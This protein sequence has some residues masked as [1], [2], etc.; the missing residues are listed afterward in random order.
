MTPL[1]TSEDNFGKCWLVLAVWEVQVRVGGSCGGWT[2]PRRRL[3][4]QLIDLFL[5]TCLIHS[6]IRSVHSADPDRFH[7]LAFWFGRPQRGT[8]TSPLFSVIKSGLDRMNQ[9][10]ERGEGRVCILL[11]PLYLRPVFEDNCSVS[12]F[13]PAPAHSHTNGS[14]VMDHAIKVIHLHVWHQ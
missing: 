11:P 1:T 9:T 14:P 13:S 5:Q 8:R 7:S 4:C 10:R 2:R 6:E 3:C 12:C